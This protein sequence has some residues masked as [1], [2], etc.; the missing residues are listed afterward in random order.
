[1]SRHLKSKLAGRVFAVAALCVLAQPAVASAQTPIQYRVSFPEP[2]H[3]WLQVELTVAELGAQPLRARMSR[4]SPGRYAV[5][6]FAKNIF[7]LEAYDGQG[8]P[9]V[10]RRSHVDEWEVAGHDGTVR[11]VYRIFG[12]TPDGTYMGVDTTHAHMNMPATF[13]WVRGHETR[14]IRVEFVPPDG[15][16]WTVGTQLYPTPDPFVYTAPNLQYFLDSPTELAN[17]LT[18][19]FTLPYA[20]GSNATVRVFVHA[21]VSQVDVDALARMVERLA[22]EHVAVWHEL[23]RFEPG[24]Y[25]FL[26]DYV[27]WADGDGMEHRNSTSISDPGVRLDTDAGRLDALGTISHE[28]FHTWNV[29]RIRPVGLEP[30][31]FT[32]ENVTCCLWLA[33][34]FTSYYGPLLIT[35]AGFIDGPPAGSALTVMAGTSA[36]EV[37]SAVEMSEHAPFNDAATSVDAH[38]RGRT[39]IS[40]YTYGAAVALALDLSLRELTGGATTL[41]DYMRLLW[42]RHGRPGGAQPGHVDRPYSLGDLRALLAELTGDQAFADDFFDR[43]V[44]G[45]EAADYARLLAQAGYVVRERAAGTGWVG[46]VP[47]QQASGGLVIRGVVP[48]GT[49]AY[50]AGLDRG[51]VIVAVDGA[52]ATMAAWQG[53]SRRRA[54]SMMT[55]T[56][57]RRDGETVTRTVTLAADP[58]MQIVPIEEAGGTL[59]PEQRAFR[60]SW[61]SSKVR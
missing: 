22:R 17:W 36:R 25:T 31:D 2:E 46:N 59:T 15:S 12:D 9:L 57:R 26:L 20:D 7:R 58:A 19:S 45:R 11:V 39:F 3:H 48:F 1:M 28:F 23:P 55:V 27:P 21:Q 53:V 50:E 34:G 6:E 47:V 10:A 18:T 54:G 44:E 33:E 14:P 41:D 5:H 4:S 43:Y 61:L 42:E 30:F 40:Y 49:P 38:D 56:I 52:P 29:E 8:R 13:L 35:R 16:G 32:Q 37:R 60:E 24:H 51:D